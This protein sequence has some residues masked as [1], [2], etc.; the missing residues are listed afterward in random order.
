MQVIL[1]R[2]PIFDHQQN[3]FAYEI[4][5]RAEQRDS[6][7]G[8]VPLPAA[9]ST[10]TDA[11][12]LLGLNRI[13]RG[14]KAFIRCSAHTNI[15]DVD[16]GLPANMVVVEVLDE[17]ELDDRF[18]DAC[19]GL[20]AAGY[21]LAL[22]DFALR[23]DP[24]HPVF[25]LVDF[26]RVDQ[27]KLSHADRMTTVDRTTVGRI[28]LLA[29]GVDTADEF[30]LAL[31]AGCAHFQGNFFRYPEVISGKDIPSYKLNHLRILHELHR[32]DLDFAAMESVIRQD[33]ALTFKLL[34]CV[35]SVFF[36]VRPT[37]SSIHHA[38]TLLGEREIR[39]WAS[40]VILGGLTQDRPAE[41][42]VTSLVRAHFCG[43]LASVAGLQNKA[44]E[45]FLM[46]LLS[47]LDAIVGR[48]MQEITQ[49]MPLATA[50]K[51]ALVG[52]RNQYRD[53]LDL[54][55]SYEKGDLENF[56]VQ[57]FQFHLDEGLITD[58]YL[59]AIDL[60]EEAM[61]LYGPRGHRE[62]AAT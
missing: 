43:A 14:K 60:T 32:D 37:V 58:L 22:G 57:S 10:S 49:D 17:V 5:Y 61:Q 48:P 29:H 12:L 24:M 39:K 23:L 54:V 42:L 33:V 31:N 2:Q 30:Q 56:L 41:L 7:D 11:A 38:M 35:N 3:V 50:L 45:F 46:G 55:L 13:T 47:L 51:T 4:L 40:L 16:V 21:Q 25:D 9:I 59:L 19:K 26:I 8:S 62:P 1:V 27:G 52:G 36:G 18:I 44:A 20:R 28:K 6:A 34:N 53:V 15:T